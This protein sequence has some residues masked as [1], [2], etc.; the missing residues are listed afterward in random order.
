MLPSGELAISWLEKGDGPDAAEWRLAVGS[1]DSEEFDSKS[2]LD[3]SASRASGISALS[4]HADELLFSCA[5]MSER[6]VRAFRLTR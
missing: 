1:R 2:L 5:D 4:S 6:R 3:A